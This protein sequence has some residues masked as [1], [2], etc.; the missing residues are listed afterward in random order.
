MSI[1]IPLLVFLVIVGQSMSGRVELQ[2]KGIHN[3][4]S[5]GHRFRDNDFIDII[6]EYNRTEPGHQFYYLAVYKENDYF[7]RRFKDGGYQ[8]YWEHGLRGAHPMETGDTL[9]HIQVP[10]ATKEA[11]GKYWAA[12]NYLESGYQIKTR[13]IK[14]VH[15]G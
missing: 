13:P 12:I 3:G 11:A 9:V 10:N 2:I 7:Y 8:I 5:T 6:V 1:G 14:L 4:R 15:Y